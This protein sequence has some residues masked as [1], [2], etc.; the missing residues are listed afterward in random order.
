MIA[1]HFDEYCTEELQPGPKG[2]AKGAQQ[3][4]MLL[5]LLLWTALP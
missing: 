1:E 3:P 4:R 5:L 2:P